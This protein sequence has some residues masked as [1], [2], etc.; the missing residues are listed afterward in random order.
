MDATT[1]FQEVGLN[2]TRLLP[3]VT[4]PSVIN[5]EELAVSLA[6]TLLDCGLSA[7]EVTLRSETALAAIEKIASQVPQICVGAGSL[8]QPGQIASV[9]QA[10]AAFAVSP[11]ATD[12]LIDAAEAAGLPLVPGAETASEVLRL[13]ARG[14]SLQ[15]F[16]PAEVAGGVEKLRSLAAPLP[17][18]HFCPTGGINLANLKDY[19]AQSNVACVGGSWFVPVTSI[20]EGDMEGIAKLTREAL[21]LAQESAK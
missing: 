8:R 4:L 2:D 19:L 5:A 1:L 6:K 16:F 17:E 13:H 11:G 10:G 21:A 20:R 18:V 14:Y 3:V 12:E 9:K 7:I 15:K